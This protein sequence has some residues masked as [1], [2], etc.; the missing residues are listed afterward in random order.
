MNRIYVAHIP[1][2]GLV[3]ETLGKQ[4]TQWNDTLCG[5]P[6]HMMNEVGVLTEDSL[7]CIACAAGVNI[8]SPEAGVVWKNSVAEHESLPP[9][10]LLGTCVLV[11]NDMEPAKNGA[12]VFTAAGWARAA[13]VGD[14]VRTVVPL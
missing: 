3:H 9:R 1:E 6:A 13:S 5:I 4:G 11:E 12:Y 14:A 7:T 8:K 10:A 2:D